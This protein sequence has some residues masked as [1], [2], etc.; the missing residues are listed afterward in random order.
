MS[1]SDAPQPRLLSIVVPARDEGQAIG[2]VLQALSAALAGLPCA[3]EIVVVDD[4][5]SDD[6]AVRAN[7]VAG[8]R[9]IV[10]P[11][12]LGYGHSLLRGIT[13]AQGDVIGITD[14]DGSYPASEIPA[15]LELI[16]RG[17]DHAIAERTGEHF[18]SHFALRHFYR[19]LCG[20]VVGQRVPD[21]N[22]GLRLFR[23]ELVESLR[24]DLCRG[25]SFTT[26]LTLASILGGWVVVFRPVV[27]GR[28]T[29]RSHVRLHDFLR[30]LQYLF[31]L[32]AVYNPLK[33]Y[34]PLVLTSALLTVLALGYA[35]LLDRAVGG[36]S[37]VV[38]SA[39]TLVLIGIS[40]LAYIVSR[41]GLYPMSRRQAPE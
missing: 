16:V 29:G 41:V 15:L 17:A 14:G 40:A 21:A 20:Y 34:L 11:V 31:Q 1:R 33:L 8:V 27:Y 36:I 6:T 5:S 24:G 37:A 2:S 7:A 19:L 18:R 38:L 3:T 30:T 35:L 22:S 26:S 28:R 10:N 9:V 25:F 12:N 23:R 13:A 32:I 4:A 39:T